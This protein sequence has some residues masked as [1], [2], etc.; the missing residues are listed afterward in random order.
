IERAPAEAKPV[1]DSV[2][3]VRLV[4]ALDSSKTPRGTPITAVLT[5]PVFSADRQLVL[6]EGA[7]LAG[8][9][10]F[11]KQASRFHRNGQLRFL[12]ESVRLPGQ[13]PTTMLASLE[14]V[15]ASE[16]VAVDEEGGVTVTN[17]ATRFIEP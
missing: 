16:D 1:P 5:E 4:T 9:V 12:F 2:L 7:E 10:T 15:D 13:E 8:E 14:S 3:N 17:S 6:P 11:T